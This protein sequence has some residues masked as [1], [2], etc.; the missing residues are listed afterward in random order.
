MKPLIEFIRLGF[1]HLVCIGAGQSNLK[2]WKIEALVHEHGNEFIVT[3][4]NKKTSCSSLS[5]AVQE[6]ESDK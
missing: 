3:I 4:G 2:I 6:I 5:E 1:P